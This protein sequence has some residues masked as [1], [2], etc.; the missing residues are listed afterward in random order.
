MK[1]KQ[2]R[3]GG[4]YRL[5]NNAMLMINSENTQDLCH[6]DSTSIKIGFKKI[7]KNIPTDFRS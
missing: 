3:S 1:R 2:L 7:L 6:W 5:T 4:L